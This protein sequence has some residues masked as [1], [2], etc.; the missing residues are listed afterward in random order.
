MQFNMRALF[1]LI[2]TFA[3]G[4][5]F[6]QSLKDS[7]V[8]IPF[9]SGT[10]SVQFPGGDLADRFGVNSNIGASFGLKLKSNWYLGA[11]CVYLFGNNLREDNIF[12]SITSSEGEL[13]T[14]YGDFAS[15]AVSER[16]F[17]ASL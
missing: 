10:Y 16:G 2:I 8:N 6:A 3:G 14:R 12:D 1:F 17:Y 4:C 9:L 15:T 7:T 11:E 5:T 13:I